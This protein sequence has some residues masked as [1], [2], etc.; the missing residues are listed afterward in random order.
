MDQSKSDLPAT[1]D[2]RQTDGDTL[3]SEPDPHFLP[4][5]L[6]GL[7][8]S[9]KSLPC[10]YLYDARGSQLFDQICELEEYY[11]TRTEQSITT[12]NASE[13]A[14][15]LGP[16][17]VLAELG[18]GSSTKTR[19][20]L[21]NLLEPTAYVPIDISEEH[22]LKT[23]EQLQNDYPELNIIPVVADFSKPFALPA[24]AQEAATCVYFPGST[25]G[26]FELSDARDLLQQIGDITGTNGYLLI[27]FDL[28]K[29]KQTLEAAY[30]DREGVTAEFSLN[31]LRRANEE[32]AANFDLDQF[33]HTSFYNE[34]VGRIEIYIESKI[35]QVVEIAGK[36]FDFAA[37]ERIHTEYSHKYTLE[38]FSHMAAEAGWTQKQVW[39]DSNDYFAVMLLART[40]G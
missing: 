3:T 10:K 18:S 30:D 24:T 1:D 40:Q 33:Q 26:N 23:A 12:E 27:G 29:D 16:S 21:E 36:S 17:I 35:D 13:I 34:E 9:P 22:L 37:G 19:V 15:A 11:L 39:T 14:A 6:S 32:L 7:A 8:G 2:G 38:S 4:D 20:L 25:I 31:I 5:V 28:Q